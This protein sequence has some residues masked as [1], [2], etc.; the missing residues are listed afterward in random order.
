[1]NDVTHEDWDLLN[2]YADGELDRATEKV[3][4]ARLANEPLL[5]EGLE[6]I[7]SIKSSLRQLRPVTIVPE[8]PQRPLRLARWAVVSSVFLAIGILLGVSALQQ[9][10]SHHTSVTE[11][12]RSFSSKSYI[13]DTSV[14]LDVSV[15]SSIGSLSAPDLSPSNLTLVDVRILN[16]VSGERIAMHYRGQRGCRVTLVAEPLSFQPYSG[17]SELAL[18]Y[19][20]KTSAASF[21]LVGDGMDPTRF[22]AIAAFAEATSRRAH[23]EPELRTALVDRTAEARPCAWS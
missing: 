15:G 9:E 21:H 14:S 10:S 1:M 3:I 8:E 23:D 11:L 17:P 19:A 16:A 22:A 18:N 5:R 7:K 4:A 20:W 13:I 6:S 12:H 2:A